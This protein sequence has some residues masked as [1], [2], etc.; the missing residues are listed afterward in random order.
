MRH[1]FCP[2]GIFYP[3][4]DKHGNYQLAK[5]AT[6]AVFQMQAWFYLGW[7]FPEELTDKVGVL[8]LKRW[9]WPLTVFYSDPAPGLVS[10]P[11]PY[12]S[13]APVPPNYWFLSDYSPCILLSLLKSSLEQGGELKHKKTKSHTPYACF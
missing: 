5:P 1:D 2:Q 10:S 11:C 4:R 12:V 3:A 7:E 9:C 13:F 8:L 6:M